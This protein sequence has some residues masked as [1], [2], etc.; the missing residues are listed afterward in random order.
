MLF[1]IVIAPIYIP[2]NNVGRFSFLC[3]LS[4]IYSL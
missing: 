4:N 1:S 2:T 3:I